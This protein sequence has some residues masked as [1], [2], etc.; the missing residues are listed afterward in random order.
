MS[1]AADNATRYKAVV[2]YDGTEFF[3]YQVQPGKVTIQGELERALHAV[4]RETVR[5]FSSGRTDQGVHARGQVI[6]FD[7][8]GAVELDRLRLGVN[9]VLPPAIRVESIRRAKPDFDARRSAT[10]K[11]YRYLIWN[12]FALTPDVRLYRTHIWKKLDVAAMKRAAKL[13]EGE[14]DF[15]S[16]SANPR[17]EID[18][19][20]RTLFRLRV[21]RRGPEIVIRAEGDG[22]LYK[23]VR[24]LAGFL[25]RVGL[26][27]LTPEDG[28]RLLA[29]KTRTATVPTAPPEGLFLWKV[30]YKPRS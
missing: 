28:P 19:T 5:V 17:R 21:D 3:G 30:D 8:V 4:T 14:H 12:S 25:I 1:R 20:V 2:S 27:E 10:G 23:M 15:A 6:H 22:F 29:T 9:A 11:E 16:F 13:L 18:G 26:G 24:S 7:L